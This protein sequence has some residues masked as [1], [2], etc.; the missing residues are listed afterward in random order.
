MK[1]TVELSLYPLRDDPIPVIKSFIEDLTVGPGIE[2]V[3]NQMSTQ[4]RGELTSVMRIVEQ[5]LS[6]SFSGSQHQVLV[7]KFINAD[8]AI[9]E[10][11]EL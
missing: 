6:R 7:A 3:T 8:L 9:A 2:C 5:A 4:L 10:P 1:V 11:P